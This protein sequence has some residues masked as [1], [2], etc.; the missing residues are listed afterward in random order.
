MQLV[1]PVLVSY[2]PGY[3]DNLQIGHKFITGQYRPDMPSTTKQKSHR[4]TDCNSLVIYVFSILPENTYLLYLLDSLYRLS[5]HTD[6]YIYLKHKQQADWEVFIQK[7]TFFLTC[8]TGCASSHSTQRILPKGTN[9]RAED[10]TE[11][12][13]TAN[14]LASWNGRRKRHSCSGTKAVYLY[15]AN[16]INGR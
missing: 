4:L 2:L 7:N 10:T 6:C 5:A 11:A 3:A 13:A 1:A 16:E 14:H 15:L 12:I 8:G 9:S